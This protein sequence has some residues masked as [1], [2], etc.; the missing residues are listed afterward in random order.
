MLFRRLPLFRPDSGHPPPPK[1]STTTMTSIFTLSPL[2]RHHGCHLQQPH[3]TTITSATPSPSLSRHHHH[4]IRPPPPSS[5]LS[6]SPPHHHLGCQRHLAATT[7][8]SPQ[9]PR[10]PRTTT[11]LPFLL[12]VRCPTGAFGSVDNTAYR[13]VWF[14]V[15]LPLR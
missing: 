8:S 15:L 4:I 12:R 14:A 3:T 13:G 10:Q 5:P 2:P 7:P 9:L 6:T 11:T 1:S